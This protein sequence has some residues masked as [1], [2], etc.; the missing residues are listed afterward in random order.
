[1]T[2][3]PDWVVTTPGASVHT[4]PPTTRGW[5]S[6]SQDQLRG[7]REGLLRS[8]LAMFLQ[9]VRGLFIPGPL[10][11]VLAQVSEWSA[12]IPILGDIVEAITGIEDGDL[13]DLGTWFTTLKDGLWAAFTGLGDTGHPLM[14]IINVIGDGINDLWERSTAH[15]PGLIPASHIVDASGQ[16]CISGGSFPTA[17]SVVAGHGW[18]WDPSVGKTKPGS[19]KVVLDGSVQELPST[20][21]A[22]VAGDIITVKASALWS[23]LTYTGSDPIA[24][25]VT[26]YLDS[27]ALHTRETLITIPSPAA[28]GGWTDLSYGY[29]VSDP[30]VK[31]IKVRPSHPAT[32]TAGTVNWDDLSAVKSGGVRDNSVPGIGTI[33]YNTVLGLEDLTGIDINHDGAL[34]A[35]QTAA[36][37]T[38]ANASAISYLQALA[39]GGVSMVDD[40]ERND[41]NGMGGNWDLT[42]SGSGAGVMDTDGHAV[43]WNKSGTGTYACRARWT[44]TPSVTTTNTQ[45]LVLVQG[46][47]G[48][49]NAFYSKSGYVYLDGRLNPATVNGT[50]GPGTHRIRATF[51]AD[52]E[53]AL[54][55]FVGGAYI[56]WAT[57]DIDP[58]PGNG[59]A[60]SLECGVGNNDRHYRVA[61]NDREVIYYP[62]SGTLSSMGAS[63]LGVG[64]GMMAE[65]HLL[66]LQQ[67]A[68]AKWN[69]WAAWDA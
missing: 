5:E 15:Q 27:N 41:T 58:I 60:L 12:G 25:G 36:Q 35:F 21:I 57:V 9:A 17:R 23:G 10:R 50:D 65:G 1:M 43:T 2:T 4:S 52:G 38:R 8:L 48:Q 59:A 26:T 46:S 18:S 3:P 55:Y 69:S 39:T 68:P 13:T 32:A 19:A 34:G 29:V 45:K 49:T 42:Y 33:L 66:L 14:D 56:P 11:D 47:K 37:A 44:G 30:L 20:R 51:G 54:G 31:Y 40:F 16:N 62:E 63:Y 53:V 64:G 6:L 22:V 24:L 7:L 61:V 67:M 28:A